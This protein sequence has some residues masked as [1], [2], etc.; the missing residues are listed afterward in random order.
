[1]SSRIQYKKPSPASKCQQPTKHVG[2]LTLYL[3]MRGIMMK[4]SEFYNYFS[5][6]EW[7][8]IAKQLTI[9]HI[10]K[11]GKRIFKKQM[12]AYK[13]VEVV[14]HTT[15]LEAQ[16]ILIPQKTN[17]AYLFFSRFSNLSALIAA[18]S[19]AQPEIKI[20]SRLFSGESLQDANWEPGVNLAENQQIVIDYLFDHIYTAERRAQGKASCILVAETGA[21]KTYMGCGII[22]QIMEKTLIMLPNTAPLDEWLT[23]F[24]TVFPHLSIGQYHSKVVHIDGD[25][26]IMTIDS[27]LS[28]EFIFTEESIP[29]TKYFQRF[30]LIIYDEIHS[31]PTAKRSEI[32]WRANFQNSLALTATPDER[33]DGMDK[34][35]ECHLGEIIRATDIPGYS[36][37]QIV[38]HGEVEIIRYSGPKEYTKPMTNAMGWTIP[39][40]MC[41][42]FIKDPHRTLLL[43]HKIIDLY[44]AKKNIFVFFELRDHI[45]CIKQAL[46]EYT[47]ENTDLLAQ[48]EAPEI[49]IFMGGITPELKADITTKARIILI[50]YGYGMQSISISRMDAIILATPRRNKMRQTIGRILRRS[51]DPTLMRSIIDIVDEKTRLREQLTTR[52]SVYVEKGFPIKETSISYLDLNTSSSV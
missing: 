12:F 41:Q 5:V 7:K 47:T 32:W 51:G 37:S 35:V 14:E 24:K 36:L 16:S 40:K 11:L 42:Q 44:N 19:G 10:T 21:G 26:V 31:F 1:M 45:N 30:G 25:I 38:W 49:G 17:D 29:W 52:H 34:L 28:D 39:I 18:L 4:E 33:A 15:T 23:A 6:D 46:L 13:R 8:K 43:V 50:T 22:E 2:T 48:I 27:A 20:C 3:T 9:T